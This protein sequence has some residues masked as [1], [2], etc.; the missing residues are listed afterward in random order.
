[1]CRYVHYLVKYMYLKAIENMI[2][3]IGLP[4]ITHSVTACLGRDPDD[5]AYSAALRSDL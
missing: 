3:R 1:M 4:R 5:I 2:N